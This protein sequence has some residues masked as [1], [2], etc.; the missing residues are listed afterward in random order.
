MSQATFNEA[1]AAA[2]R[3][4]FPDATAIAICRPHGDEIP[5]VPCECGEPLD[6]NATG[7]PC[8]AGAK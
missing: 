4:R 6:C 8:R 2:V 5:D 7:S 1:L 3:T